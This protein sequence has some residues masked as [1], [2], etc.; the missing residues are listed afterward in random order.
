M[1]KRRRLGP[2]THLVAEVPAPAPTQAPETK[3]ALGPPPIAQVSAEAAAA[4]ALSELS[5][6][7]H[8]AR[9]EGR[10]LERIPLDQI[11][12]GHLIRDRMGADEEDLNALVTSIRARGQA[13]PI[14][15]S[16]L[17]DTRYGLISGWRR[18]LALSRLATEDP[19]YGTVMARVIAPE[20]AQAAY[21]AMVEENEI[22]VNL[23]HY[24]RAQLVVRAL[25]A[26]VFENDREALQE[27]FGNV[28]RSK[29]SKVGSFMRIVRELGDHLRFPLELSERQGLAMA[30]VVSID[31]TGGARLRRALHEAEAT[32][33]EAEARALERALNPPAPKARP[34]PPRNYQ[35]TWREGTEQITI[36][37]D[38]VDKDLH[39]ALEVFL[40]K[41][42]KK[43]KP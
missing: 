43:P 35:L 42:A 20:T 13:T 2:A 29:R 8:T 14:E 36:T 30:K 18:M 41:Q 11:D 17:G 5:G 24:E 38:L 12:T 15:V 28:S 7:V 33:A 27:M 26:G 16:K 40:K 4:N 1:A 25:A 9:A 21:V 10:I 39:A 22:R 34:V 6:M 32:D 19:A 23:T 37:G 31:P 3:S